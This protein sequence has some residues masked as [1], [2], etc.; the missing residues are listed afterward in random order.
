MMNCKFVVGGS[1]KVI[2]T[3]V[4]P[5]VEVVEVTENS[6]PSVKLRCKESS[7]KTQSRVVDDIV[8]EFKVPN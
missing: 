4:E 1:H 6:N 7:F 2:E 5:E 3:E 8:W